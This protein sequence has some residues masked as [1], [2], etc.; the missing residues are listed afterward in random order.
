MI[1]RV[2]THDI[3]FGEFLAL[4]MILASWFMQLLGSPIEL[5]TGLVIFTQ[6][7]SQNLCSV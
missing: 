3:Q 7:G 5:H 1:I 6:S 4:W 2:K